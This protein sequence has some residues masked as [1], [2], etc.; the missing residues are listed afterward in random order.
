M[1]S[2]QDLDSGHHGSGFPLPPFRAALLRDHLA[3]QE[4]RAKEVARKAAIPAAEARAA[5][6]KEKQQEIGNGIAAAT[7][8]GAPAGKLADLTSPL[9]AVKRCWNAEPGTT[10]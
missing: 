3:G 4:F 7:A 2:W 5:L 10:G 8:A 9:P 1:K 6:L